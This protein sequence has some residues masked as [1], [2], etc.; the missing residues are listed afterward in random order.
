MPSNE[1]LRAWAAAAGTAG[2]VLPARVAAVLG[3]SQWAAH[4][5]QY[6]VDDPD[7]IWDAFSILEAVAA[8]CRS[9]YRED[10]GQYP[11]P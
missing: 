8:A 6:G 5:P 11:M 10:P 1:G 7:D 9:V 3:G 4:G 2:A